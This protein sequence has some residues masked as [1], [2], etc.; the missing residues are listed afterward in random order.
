MNLV[1]HC[2]GD[3]EQERRQLSSQRP[4]EGGGGK[5]GETRGGPRRCE[6]RCSRAEAPL[7]CGPGRRR[8]REPRVRRPAARQA[9]EPLAEG[10]F[11]SRRLST[12]LAAVAAAFLLVPSAW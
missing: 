4:E 9:P 10:G 8:G 7:A 11:V 6:G 5:P 3:P 12:V 1:G 2:V